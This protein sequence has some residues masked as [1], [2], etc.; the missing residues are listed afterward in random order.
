MWTYI[1]LVWISFNTASDEFP[2][3]WFLVLFLVD[4]VLQIREEESKRSPKPSPE[5]LLSQLCLFSWNVFQ[6]MCSCFTQSKQ[7]SFHLS[8]TT[9]ALYG[10]KQYA[11]II[12]FP[13]YVYLNVTM[14]DFWRNLPASTAQRL[15]SLS[16]AHRIRS[17]EHS[18][19]LTNWA[20]VFRAF[21]H[22]CSLTVLCGLAYFFITC[23][24][25]STPIDL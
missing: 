2:K 6:S 22:C 15:L 4:Q 23:L 5:F 20:L 3:L 8:A 18:Q 9:N 25:F 13:L 16:P 17:I 10:H 21:Y 12:A 11:S 7:P 1:V 24:S 14:Q 19:A